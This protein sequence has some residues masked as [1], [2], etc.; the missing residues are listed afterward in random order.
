MT[1]ALGLI[2]LQIHLEYQLDSNGLLVP[3][4]GSSEQGLYIAYR[5]AGG[6]VQYFNHCLPIELRTR[7]VELGGSQA[8]EA[9]Q[10]VERLIQEVTPA[11][12][13]GQFV[14]EYI[15]RLPDPGGFP[16]V[17]TQ[18]AQ[19]VILVDGSPVCWA[20]SE[21]SNEGCAEV[22]V[23]TL[24]QHRRKGYARQ[25]V[26]A[27][28]FEVIGSGRTAFYSYQF[29]NEASRALARSLGAVWYADVV[30]FA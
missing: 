9:P 19:S 5:H 29:E 16:L 27:W 12:F 14:S 3:F 28:A 13:E 26:A 21:R 18:Q 23:E 1:T 8:F 30:C 22:A 11:R 2:D 20:W 10:V 25:V 24:P 15:P 4:P 7:L 17:V 6:T